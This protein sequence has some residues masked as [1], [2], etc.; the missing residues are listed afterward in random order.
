LSEGKAVVDM[1]TEE[2]SGETARHRHRGRE[3]V[4][5]REA[6]K[7]GEQK[8]VTHGQQREGTSILR[9]REISRRQR[10]EQR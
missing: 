8:K 2:Q 1:F 7:V 9:E 5:V 3:G 10:N 6:G 4:V